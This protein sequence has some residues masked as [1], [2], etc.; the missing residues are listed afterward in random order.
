M[1]VNLNVNKLYHPCTRH[2]PHVKI[3]GKYTKAS[4]VYT[5]ALASRIADVLGEEL[6][7]K[8]AA[9]NYFDIKI[10]GLES[11]LSNH[12]ALASEWK[13]VKSWTWERRK[14]TSMFWRLRLMVDFAIMLLSTTPAPDFLLG[15]TPM[16]PSPPIIKGRSPSLRVKTFIAQD[17]CN[18]GRWVPL[19][20][21]SLFSYSDETP[22]IT[23]PEIPS[24]LRVPKEASFP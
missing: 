17:W 5:D 10:E 1:G 9:S 20:G 4:A 15:W 11:V 12:F 8:K 18:D 21:S 19:P 23:L 24:S 6:R 2:H 22:A 3:E 14:S 13:E 7:I 16:W